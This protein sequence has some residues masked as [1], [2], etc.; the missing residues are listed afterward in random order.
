MWV[1][2]GYS[3]ETVNQEFTAREKD[4]IKVEYPNK[5][6]ILVQSNNLIYP[7]NYTIETYYQ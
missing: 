4:I 5:A 6:Y 7:G 1:Y 2:T 3:F